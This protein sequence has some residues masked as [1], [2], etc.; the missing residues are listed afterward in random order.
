MNEESVKVA[1]WVMWSSIIL[2]TTTPSVQVLA[3]VSYRVIKQGGI[4]WKR[5]KLF[6]QNTVL[7]KN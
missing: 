2:M 4:K 3:P 1:N 5:Y 6:I 7:G